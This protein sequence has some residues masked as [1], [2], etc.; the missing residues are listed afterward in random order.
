MMTASTAFATTGEKMFKNLQMI[1]HSG[2]KSL[3]NCDQSDSSVLSAWL[4]KRKSGPKS[5]FLSSTNRRFFILDF[6]SQILFYKH[7]ESDK[8]ISQPTSFRNIIS[9]QPLTDT[10]ADVAD[11]GAESQAGQQINVQR[12]D[13]KTSLASS[14][15]KRMPSFSTPRSLRAPTQKHGFIIETPDKPL[16]LLCSSKAEADQW[17]AA[18]QQAMLLGGRPKVEQMA[19]S[20]TST[21]ASSRPTTACSFDSSLANTNCSDM[22]PRQSPPSS[23]LGDDHVKSQQPAFTEHTS[24]SLPPKVPKRPPVAKAKPK[25]PLLSPEEQTQQSE[26]K[27][28]APEKEAV[29]KVIESTNGVMEYSAADARIEDDSEAWGVAQSGSLSQGYPRY[30]DKSEGLSLQE[31]LAQLDFSD[32]EDEDDSDVHKNAAHQTLPVG[33]TSNLPAGPAVTTFAA[34]TVEP[35]Q[36]FTA[37]LSDSDDE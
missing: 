30:H 15:R 33:S 26:M 24:A 6:G 8:K 7:S 1:A 9:V 10:V 17:I 36:P 13:S 11:D 23:R 32:D 35:C 2:S 16:E 5:R 14:L 19:R 28:P 12:A 34:V 25:W 31:R 27:T 37:D 29:I 4:L 22:S 20:D 18:L 21:A 3:E